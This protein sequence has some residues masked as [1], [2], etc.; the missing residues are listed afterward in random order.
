MVLRADDHRGHPTHGVP[1]S[2]GTSWTQLQHA[3]QDAGLGQVQQKGRLGAS[4]ASVVVA[5]VMPGEGSYLGG[6][7]RSEMML[8][9]GTEHPACVPL[10]LGLGLGA[11]EAPFSRHSRRVGR[12]VGWLVGLAWLRSDRLGSWSRPASARVRGGLC[13]GLPPGT[14]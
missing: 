5:N 10:N 7:F 8:K 6:L 12:E 3:D 11:G 2:S 1:Q 13:W 14:F 9:R 4:V